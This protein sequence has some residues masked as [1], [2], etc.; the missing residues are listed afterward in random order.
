MCQVCLLFLHNS[1][2]WLTTLSDY[3]IPRELFAQRYVKSE[4]IMKF[5]LKNGIYPLSECRAIQILKQ[6]KTSWYL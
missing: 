3:L 5:D 1:H 6:T 2:K 4:K